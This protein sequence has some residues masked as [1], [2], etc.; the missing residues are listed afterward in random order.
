MAAQTL[1]SSTEASINQLKISSILLGVF[2]EAYRG[3]TPTSRRALCSVQEEFRGRFSC[4]IYYRSK[5]PVLESWSF[6]CMQLGCWLWKHSML[7]GLLLALCH[8][9]CHMPGL[10]LFFRGSLFFLVRLP[11]PIQ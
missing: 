10:F 8:P 7:P 9:D 4:K 3:K 1:S 11:G 6:C 2:K 5:S